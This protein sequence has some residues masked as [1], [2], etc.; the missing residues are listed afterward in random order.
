M[1]QLINDLLTFSR[2]NRLPLNKQSVD[3]NKMV[4]SVLADFQEERQR[5]NMEITVQ[6]LPPCQADPVLLHQVW[7]NLISNA[8]KYTRNRPIAKIEIGRLDQEGQPVYFIRDN[9]AGF[10]MHLAGKLFGVFQRL[11]S[12]K[13]Y[14]GT[15]VGLAV[16]H[17]IIQRHGGCIWAEAAVDKG[18]VFYLAI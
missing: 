5:R 14:E 1:A 4:Q 12:D 17:R 15:G 8:F 3:L 6:E 9:G 11:H 10:D 18:A 16:V 13:E 2:F 7:V